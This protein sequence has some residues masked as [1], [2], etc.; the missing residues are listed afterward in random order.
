M[1]RINVYLLVVVLLGIVTV[2]V[3]KAEESKVSV[4][5]FVRIRVCVY[6]VFI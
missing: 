5:V 6:G 1:T 2:P 3:R 4:Y